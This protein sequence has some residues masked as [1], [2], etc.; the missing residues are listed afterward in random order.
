MAGKDIIMATQEELRRLHVIEKVLEKGLKQVEA[1]EILSL[2]W[3]QIGRM[4]KRVKKEGQR[5]IV[6]RSRG[7]PSNRKIADQLKEKVIELYRKSYKGFGP[8][9]ACEKLLE[10]DGVRI[11]D[12]TL[13]VWLLES[14]DWKRTRKRKKHRQ[15]RERKK[16]PGELVQIDGSHHAWFE[17]RGEPCVLMGYIDDAKGNAFGRFYDH[18]GTMPAM[19]SFRRYVRKYGLPLKVYLDGLSTY[20]STAKPTIQEQLEGVEPLSEFERALKELRVEVSHAHSPQAKG[21]IERL[22]R[23]FQDRLIKEMRL[24]GIGTIEEGN[25]FL[26]EYLP[27]YNKRFSVRPREKE[28]LH[29]PLPKGLD[30]KAILCIKTERTVRNDFTVAHNRK[31]YQIEEPTKATKVIVQDRMDGS[32]RIT[33][34]DHTLRFREITERPARENK[35]P[36]TRRRRRTYIPPADHPWRRFKIKNHPYGRERFLESQI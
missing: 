22:F 25:R 17:D 3:R 36:V 27:V 11:S 5:G 30:L 24:K 18:E 29:R 8:T 13:R 19:D 21:R 16:H 4:V 1:A 20:K 31:L 34:Q 10:R 32:I 26:A 14:G 35:Q 23:T 28:D 15:W 12:E 6:H 7:R 33:H 9:L 2:S